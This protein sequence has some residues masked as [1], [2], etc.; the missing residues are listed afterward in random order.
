MAREGPTTARPPDQDQDQD[1]D[2][3]HH[4]LDGKGGGSLPA[5]TSC[6]FSVA[7]ARTMG[8]SARAS[9]SAMDAVGAKSRRRSVVA[10]RNAGAATGPGS[11]RECLDG[12]VARL[13]DQDAPTCFFFFGDQRGGATQGW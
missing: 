1:Q 6:G 5:L 9:A 8:A 10:E 12:D 4:R 2:A 3:G 11:H 7:M 13:R